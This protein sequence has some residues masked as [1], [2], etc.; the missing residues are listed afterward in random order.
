MFA[1]N[2]TIDLYTKKANLY[3]RLFI[4]TLYYPKGMETFFKENF[5]TSEKHLTILDAGT[6]T[7]TLIK[8]LFNVL[9]ESEFKKIHFTAFDISSSMLIRLKHWIKEKRID[10]I[11]VY[12]ADILTL[13]KRKENTLYDI[14]L[15][16]GMLEYISKNEFTFALA[17]L[18]NKLKKTGKLILFI[19]KYSLL[20]I[21]LIKFW[22]KANLFSK[23]ELASYVKKAGFQKIVFHRFPQRYT[24][25]NWWGYI[26]EA[27]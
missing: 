14:I 24:Y 13:D 18:R 8:A 6:G 12:Q 27:N 11:N 23:D 15:S 4:D 1:Q 10:N 16:S 9:P 25:L 26:I 17:L 22:W 19:S 3:E 21:F 20:N 5:A 7:G 2:K